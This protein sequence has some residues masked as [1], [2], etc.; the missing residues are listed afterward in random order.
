MTFWQILTMWQ[1]GNIGNDV[2]TDLVQFHIQTSKY[3]NFDNK[4]NMSTFMCYWYL[5]IV[6]C[7]SILLLSHD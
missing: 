2:N 7:V 1:A 6:D 3:F 4:E 5:A